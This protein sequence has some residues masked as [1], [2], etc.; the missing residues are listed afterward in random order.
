VGV[1]DPDWGESVVAYV[2]PRPGAEIDAD[3]LD[4][5]CLNAIARYKRP[6][7]YRVVEQ[8]PRNPAGKVLKS[9]LRAMSSRAEQ[10][11]AG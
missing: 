7:E 11:V 4:S 3:A 9:E 10:H 8:L 1:P 5:R 2:V 6:R